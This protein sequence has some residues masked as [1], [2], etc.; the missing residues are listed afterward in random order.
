MRTPQFVEIQTIDPNAVFSVGEAAWLLGISH[1]GLLGRIQAGSICAGRSGH[2]YFIL[3]SEIQ[4]QIQM[5]GDAKP[6]AEAANV[7]KADSL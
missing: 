7:A 3:G 4:K 6:A 2:R 1:N 5:P